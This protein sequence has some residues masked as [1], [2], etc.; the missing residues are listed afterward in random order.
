[1]RYL[2][3]CG[4]IAAIAAVIALSL[5]GQTKKHQ[6]SPHEKAFYADAQTVE[7]VLPGLAITINS[8]KIASDGT[9]TVVYSIADP[10]GLPLDSAGV[11]TPGTVGLSFVAATIPNNQ[12]QYTAYTTRTATGTVIASTQQPGA[13]S[14]GTSTAVAAGQY[15]YVFHTKAPTGF[16]ATATHT[17]GV[18]GSRN[19]TAYSLGTNYAS[20]TFNFVPNG[21][22]VTHVRD[23][24]ETASC[25]S[26]HDQLSAHGGSRR[27]MAMC[28]LCHTPQNSD[29]NTGLTLDAKVFFHKIH[30]GENLPSVVAGTP[31]I[32]AINAFGSF[33]Y[34]TVAFPAD[35][36]DPRRCEVCHSQTTGAAQATAYLSNPTRAACGACHDDVNFA[37]GVNH[38]G[39]PQFDDNLCSTCHIPQGEMDFDASI[40]GAHV[41]PTASSLLSGLAVNITKV[42]NGT[43][44]SAPVVSF[45]VLNNAGQGIP[46][47]QLGSIS[48]TMAGPTTDYGY[49]SFGSNVTTPGYVTES[50]A[51]A[52]CDNSGN[53]MY[54]FTHTVPPKS[55][56]TYAIGVEARRTETVL[57]GTTSQQSIQYGA[58]NKVAYFSVDGSPMAARRTVVALSNCNQCHVVL[59]IHGTLRN[60]TEYCVMCHNPSNT[61]ASVRVAATNAAD[62]AAPPQGINFN[63]LVHRI[64]YGINMQA[65][66]RSYVVVGF[67]G[68]HNDFSSTLF[69]AM[70]PTGAATDTANCSLCHVNSSEQNA[71]TQGALNA[72]VDPQGP[73]NPIQPISSACTGCHVDLPTASHALA[74]TTSLGEACAVCHASGAAYAVDQVHAQY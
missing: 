67:G 6:F 68:S 46:L 49:T 28:V 2:Y 34:S 61:D 17:I 26:C 12:E 43:A 48:F 4:R 41:A 74:N 55:T 64:H 20:A 59:S 32:P 66:N 51:G 58:P 30:M 70:S 9:I 11:T 36:G 73:I 72:V 27:G 56:G 19:L 21:A 33:N 31:Y 65:A 53:C 39:G 3:L 35:P 38:A 57:A 47:S 8:A 1:M 29:P 60:N 13:D 45:T 23:V 71:L 18:Y 40:K 15:Q 37:T 7:F 25:N 16:D 69:P 54:T 24:I 52:T 5:T 14:G 44:G 10:N 42:Q 62:K 22:K 50:A 63:L